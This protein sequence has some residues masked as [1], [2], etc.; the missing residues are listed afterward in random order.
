[1]LYPSSSAAVALFGAPIPPSKP[2]FDSSSLLDQ[3]I[4]NGAPPATATDPLH[5]RTRHRPLR[6]DR[7][8]LP[9]CRPKWRAT[10][11]RYCLPILKRQP[12]TKVATLARFRARKD[13]RRLSRYISTL[14]SAKFSGR[15]LEFSR[16]HPEDVSLPP[17][18]NEHTTNCCE[19]PA[20]SSTVPSTTPLP[21]VQVYPRTNI[22]AQ[23]MDFEVRAELQMT[24]DDSS[25]WTYSL[26]IPQG[27]PRKLVS[28]Y[29]HHCKMCEHTVR[30]QHG[31]VIWV[32]PHLT[33]DLGVVCV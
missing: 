28:D 9:S 21:Q 7:S 20:H 22:G 18:T 19:E 32:Q 6:R 17:E 26:L 29:P 3:S 33:C 15:W 11:Y 31:G 24:R 10:R 27:R 5:G 25:P 14:K 12:F 4:H 30:K 2:S 13:G 23:S 8:T 16:L 1:M